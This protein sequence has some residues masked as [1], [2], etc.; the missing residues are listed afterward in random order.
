MS[1]VSKVLASYLEQPGGPDEACRFALEAARKAT[2][3]LKERHNLA[4]V[5]LLSSARSARQR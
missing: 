4:A 3:K 5:S 2:E 1:R